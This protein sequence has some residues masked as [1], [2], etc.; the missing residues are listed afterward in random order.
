MLREK[1]FVLYG[2]PV[3][4]LDYQTMTRALCGGGGGGG[5]APYP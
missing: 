1:L 2:L 3:L 5:G 4:E